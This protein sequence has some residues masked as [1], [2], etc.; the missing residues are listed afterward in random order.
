MKKLFYP[1]AFALTVF[2]ILY[3]CSAEE[4]DSYLELAK[5]FKSNGK[6]YREI[7]AALKEKGYEVSRSTLQR[8]I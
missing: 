8:K 1:F 2:L 7:K 4:E 6:S 3:S 5:E